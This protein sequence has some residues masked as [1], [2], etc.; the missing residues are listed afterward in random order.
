MHSQV[1]HK[2]VT[3]PGLG[4][5]DEGDLESES[6]PGVSRWK[7]SWWWSLQSGSGSAATRWDLR[8]GD[9]GSKSNVKR[10]VHAQVPPLPLW[11]TR[12][13]LQVPV[14]SL[15][16]RASEQYVIHAQALRHV[17]LLAALM[18]CSPPGSSVHGI[19]QVRILEW[20]AYPF[21]RGS[22]WPRD[23]TQVSHIAG[24]FFTIW[25]T[26]EAHVPN[27][28]IQF[29]LKSWYTVLCVKSCSPKRNVQVLT[30]KACGCDLIW[31]C[32]LCRCHQTEM[33][34]RVDPNP[35]WRYP[36]K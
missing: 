26:R 27:Y 16:I 33:L 31:K 23:R 32:N 19:F 8:D 11:G 36:Y 4:S 12:L 1:K 21:S 20:V 28:R 30:P 25:A 14:S 34:A 7:P 5:G 15:W 6:L 22:S 2:L 9:T 10:C 17:R 18:D 35:L 3:Q 29:Y 13:L 24:R